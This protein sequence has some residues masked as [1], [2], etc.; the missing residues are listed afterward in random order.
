MK[1]K[2][3][4]HAC[5]TITAEHGIVIV[6]DPYE[7]GSFGGGIGYG[8]V[9]ERADV[10]LISHDHADHNYTGDLKGDFEVLKGA[11]NKAGIE[12]TAVQ[13]AHDASGG[14]ERGKNT[15]FAFE[16]DG[17]R[18]AFLGD[19]GHQLTEE[20]VSALGRLDLLLVPVGGVFTVDPAAAA[21]VIEQLGPRLVIPMHYKTDK[22]GFPL[23]TVDEF[24]KQFTNVKKTGKS[25]IEVEA[26]ALPG[27]TEVWILEHAR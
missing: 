1:I 7:P 24:A 9:D 6:T 27:G 23:A 13:A 8:P 20:Q 19:L 21:K 17:V 22:C 11:G 15:L 18:T 10:V 12:F 5:F 16:V 26:G 14:S 2:W 3:N 4:G 25:E